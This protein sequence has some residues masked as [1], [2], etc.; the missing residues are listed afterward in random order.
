MLFCHSSYLL[1]YL[2][3]Y[4]ILCSFVVFFF[5]L[6]IRRPPR[7]TLSSSSAASD[8][9]KRQIHT[10]VRDLSNA[11]KEIIKMCDALAEG[12][13]TKVLQ[14]AILNRFRILPYLLKLEGGRIR[15]PTTPQH[16]AA[17]L[18][19]SLHA[20]DAYQQCFALVGDDAELSQFKRV[21]R[22]EQNFCAIAP[23]AID[24]VTSNGHTNNNVT[25][26]QTAMKLTSATL[27][28]LYPPKTET[29][30]ISSEQSFMIIKDTLDRMPDRMR[31]A[32]EAA[33]VT[34]MIYF[35]CCDINKAINPGY[36]SLANSMS[37]TPMKSASMSPTRS[38]DGA[39][40]SPSDDT[41]ALGAACE[42][43][44]RWVEKDVIRR[45]PV[46]ELLGGIAPPKM[47]STPGTPPRAYTCGDLDGSFALP[48]PD[49]AGPFPS[50]RSLAGSPTGMGPQK[51]DSIGGPSTPLINHRAGTP[52]GGASSSCPGTPNVSLSASPATYFFDEGEMLVRNLNAVSTLHWHKIIAR[53][54]KA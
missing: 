17:D 20:T 18:S 28:L 23:S 31:G 12:T 42:C 52:V 49:M 21:M 19:P 16:Q 6:M 14:Y 50:Q 3:F 51:D 48:G 43:F 2:I 1:A 38:F 54:Q 15:T 37:T 34:E 27:A 39:S 33:V 32:A 10:A 44:R 53:L 5:F 9:Y 13:P 47:P 8:V 46:L 29:P 7:S 26:V 4:H 22:S 35:F 25:L 45:Q 36:N 11:S 40:M 41:A 30:K 24:A